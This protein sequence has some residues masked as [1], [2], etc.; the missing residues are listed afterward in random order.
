MA[1]ASVASAFLTVPWADRDGPLATALAKLETVL[2][3]GADDG[4]D[5]ELGP[6]HPGVLDTLR[7]AANSNRKVDI[8]YY[9]FG[10]DGHSTRVVHPWRVFNTGGQWYVRGWCERAVAQ[11]TFRVDRITRAELLDAVFEPPSPEPGGPGPAAGSAEAGGAAR[12]GGVGGA[13]WVGGV[14]G[15]GGVPVLYEPAPDDPRIVLELD[16]PAHWIAEQYPTEEVI[17]GPGPVLRVTLRV[18]QRA[19]LERLLLRA[20]PNARV[21]AGDPALRTAA[22]EAAERLLRRYRT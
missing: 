9:S 20:G 6:V 3:V 2:G 22:G 7:R 21:V 13:G 5:V 4:L 11:R 16:P 15:A 19:W 10:R 1:L 18:G 17:A 14:G 8:E 12:A